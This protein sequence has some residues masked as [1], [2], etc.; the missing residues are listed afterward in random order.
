M[1]R[2]MINCE[3]AE[4]HLKSDAL[5]AIN[6]MNNPTP[7]MAHD[8]RIIELQTPN[9]YGTQSATNTLVWLLTP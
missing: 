3:S 2:R 6:A 8:D 4:G 7:N 9:R 1:R 5:P